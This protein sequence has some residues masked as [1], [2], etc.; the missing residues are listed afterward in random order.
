MGREPNIPLKFASRFSQVS[1]PYV[2]PD[3]VA[4]ALFQHLQYY[5]AEMAIKRTDGLIVGL[6]LG[7]FL[8]IELLG[9]RKHLA[10][11]TDIWVWFQ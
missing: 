6:A 4:L 7:T 5:A 11:P 1:L 2:F 10:V 9:F 8:L 3:F